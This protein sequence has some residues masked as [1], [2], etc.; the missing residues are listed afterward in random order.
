MG[1]NSMQFMG[2]KTCQLIINGNKSR[3]L[4]GYPWIS[5]DVFGI[6]DGI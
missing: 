2:Y 1:S 4:M 3:N 5:H 6:V